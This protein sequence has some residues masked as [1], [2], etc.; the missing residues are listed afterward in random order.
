MKNLRAFKLK[1][2]G[3]T[4]HKGARISI[5]DTRHKQR[6]IISRTYE[7]ESTEQARLYLESLGI[8]CKWQT[9][10]ANILL[11]DDFSTKIK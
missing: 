9:D 1:Y 5:T 7:T 3:A 11:T 8:V 6:V 10:E 2:L 4:D